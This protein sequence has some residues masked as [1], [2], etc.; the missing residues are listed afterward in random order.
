MACKICALVWGCQLVWVNWL[1]CVES[2]MGLE[3]SRLVSEWS[4]PSLFHPLMTIYHVT[5][6]DGW[7]Q[8]VEKGGWSLLLLY[9]V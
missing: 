1:S 4:C 8:K 3:F 7:Q 5:T 6:T 9:F 2:E